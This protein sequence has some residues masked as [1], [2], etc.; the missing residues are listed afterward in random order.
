MIMDYL[1]F[2]DDVNKAIKIEADNVPDGAR[3]AL[4]C[5][6]QETGRSCSTVVYLPGNR[7]FEALAQITMDDV[8]KPGEIV[9]AFEFYD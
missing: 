5:V 6:E 1:V 3:F 9:Q 8:F 2:G 7:S 4:Q